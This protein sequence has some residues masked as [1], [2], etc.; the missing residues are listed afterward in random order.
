MTIINPTYHHLQ[1]WI[2][3][4]PEIFFSQGEIIYNA[5]NQIRVI[6]GSDG[7]FYN[8]KRYC[9]PQWFNRI[10]YTWLRPSKAQRAYENALRLQAL[11]IA[12]PRPIAYILCG[13]HLL[14]ESYLLTEQVPYTHRL[15]EWG[16]GLTDGREDLMRAFGRFTARMHQQ[17]VLHLDYSPGN[18]LYDRVDQTWQFSLVDINRM[19]F[20]PVSFAQ[21]CANMGRLWGEEAVYH[22]I[23]EG[24][25]MES[26]TDVETC[27]R[28]MWQAHQ[29]FWKNRKKPIEYQT[30][31]KSHE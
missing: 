27:Y 10:A 24:Y 5:R 29:Q 15:Y 14:A 31:I 17:G 30:K 2:E 7:Q 18:I 26:Q 16:D 3:T 11:Y 22:L 28:L 12:T 25:A 1:G 13:R 6:E 20:G 8:V 21:G 9:C 4:L 23:A 19:H